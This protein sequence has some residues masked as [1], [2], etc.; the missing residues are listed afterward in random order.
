MRDLDRRNT[1]ANTQL[2]L[3]QVHVA[4]FERNGDPGHLDTAQLHAEAAQ[5]AL[6]QTRNSEAIARAESQCVRI[7]A[8]D[9]NR[10]D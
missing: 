9:Q 2:K 4:L 1:R 6:S 5:K 10:S 7:A 3:S 8:L